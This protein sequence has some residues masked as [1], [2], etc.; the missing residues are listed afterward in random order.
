MKP[1]LGIDLTTNK[2]N[3][4]INGEEFVIAK[5][6][7]SLTQSLES[8]SENVAETIEKSKLP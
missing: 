6:A 8:S 4:Q 7:L 1:F 2:K 5:P 3:E